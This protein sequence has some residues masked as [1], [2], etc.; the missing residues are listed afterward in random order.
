MGSHLFFGPGPEGI[1]ARQ[2]HQDVA[3]AVVF[4]ISL[5]VH[6]RLAR[7][8]ARMLVQTGE[9]VEHRGFAHIGIAGQSDDPVGG[10]FLVDHQACDRYS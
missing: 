4:E 6:H 10:M 2:V 9:G 8:V 5:G 7:P 3:L 1:A